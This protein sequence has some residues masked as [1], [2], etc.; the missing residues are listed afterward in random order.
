MWKRE[1]KQEKQPLTAIRRGLAQHQLLGH[2]V[3]SNMN[4]FI[5]P[6]LQM[7]KGNKQDHSIIMSEQKQKQEYCKPQKWSSTLH[8]PPN[9]CDYRLLTNSCF[10]SA[11]F[12]L[13]WV[14]VTVTPN[15]RMNCPHFLKTPKPKPDHTSR[16]FP[17]SP[18]S[19][20]N[21]LFISSSWEAPWF[22]SEWDL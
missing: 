16:I 5:K 18:N 2:G 19:S 17:E 13:L 14:T 10:N 6:K 1:K 15:H 3:P 12:F 8:C 7:A 11:L 22:P 21:A 20:P 9:L 4:N